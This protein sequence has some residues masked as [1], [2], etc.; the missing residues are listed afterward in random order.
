MVARAMSLP[1]GCRTSGFNT[2]VEGCANT[3]DNV[4]GG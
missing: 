1:V 3:A 4:H 2:N